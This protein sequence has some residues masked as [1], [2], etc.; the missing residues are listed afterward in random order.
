MSAWV[1]WP[2]FCSSVIPATIERARASIAPSDGAAGTAARGQIASAVWHEARRVASAQRINRGR[3][4]AAFVKSSIYPVLEVIT[5]A[6]Q[7]RSPV[8]LESLQ[9]LR[10]T[11]VIVGP[12]GRVQHIADLEY[13][14]QSVE[15]GPGLESVPDLCVHLAVWPDDREAQVG[16]ERNDFALERRPVAI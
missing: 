13:D 10:A 11:H 12:V 7:P 15:P 1:I 3:A 14:A 16:E 6:E 2:T 5:R 4:A 9:R 8:F